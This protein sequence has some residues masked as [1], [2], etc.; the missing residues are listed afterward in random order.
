[1]AGALVV[2]AC[3]R[4]VVDTGIDR[5][6]GVGWGC[7]QAVRLVIGSMLPAGATMSS[8]SPWKAQMA[9]SPRLHIAASHAGRPSPA[10][11]TMAAI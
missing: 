10:I 2:G 3:P 7:G 5:E 1:M 6:F 9:T 4:V 8:A 11:G